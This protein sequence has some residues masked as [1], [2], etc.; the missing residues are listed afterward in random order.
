MS[1]GSKGIRSNKLDLCKKCGKMFLKTGA[2]NICPRCLGQKYLTGFDEELKKPHSLEMKKS[3]ST[4]EIATKE[5]DKK[6]SFKFDR[7]VDCGRNDVKH[8]ARGLCL[9]CY[10]RETSKR[11]RG[12]QRVK[13]GLAA[14]KLNYKYLFEEYVNKK[15]SLGD[16][17]KDCDCSR[18]YVYKKMQELDIPLRTQK[19]ARE[20][21]YNRDKISYTITEEN[22]K[23]R[24]ITPSSIKI[25]DN[26]FLTWSNEMAYV[27]G[28]IFTDGNI[29]PGSKRDPSQKTTTR[30]PR[31]TIAQKE[32]EL[33]NKVSKL[34]NCD[35]KLRHRKK[36]GIGGALYIFDIC[37]E[38]IYDDLINFGLSPQKSKTIEFP[39]IPQEFVCHFIRG[40]WDGDGSILFDQ[41]RLVASYISGS[42][43]FIERLVEELYKIGIS[44]G[45]LSYKFESE[46]RVLQPAT[47]EMLTKYP[48]GRFPLTVFKDKRANAYYIKIRGKEN[49]EKLFHYFYDGVDESMYLTRKYKVFVRGLKLVEKEKTEQLTLDLDF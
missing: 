15:R 8:I 30:S 42:K 1:M 31:L 3:V 7:C 46:K 35:M 13:K 10:Q 9:N 6:W 34:M 32:P 5:K 11:N 47:K 2:T 49:I 39:N 48:D 26:F 25:N 41:N 43:K 33:L 38:K 17:A 4:K 12:N 36:R 28:V 14:Y 45:G 20:L 24:L 27:L 44:K 37:S 23:E 29:N 18:Q 40:C 21:A 16:I 22:G 19:E